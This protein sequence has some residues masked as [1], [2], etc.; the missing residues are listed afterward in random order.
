MR[1]RLFLEFAGLGVLIWLPLLAAGC[2]T[3][4]T[5]AGLMDRPPPC[6]IYFDVYSSG[7]F[8]NRLW[9]VSVN[10]RWCRVQH[11]PKSDPDWGKVDLS[12]LGDGSELV[13]QHCWRY[14]LDDRGF[15]AE[16]TGNISWADDYGDI[17]IV[18]YFEKDRPVQ[19][20]VIQHKNSSGGYR[21]DMFLNGRRVLHNLD[22]HQGEVI[23]LRLPAQDL[24]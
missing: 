2:G 20:K 6:D 1:P 13:A 18:V 7:S 17:D 22:A 19:A 24:P 21:Y 5:R 12:G 10:S 8:T 15:L 14:E 9:T 16:E 3:G 11:P 23:D 4:G